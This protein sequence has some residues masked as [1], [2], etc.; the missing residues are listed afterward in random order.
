MILG[1]N[2]IQHLHTHQHSNMDLHRKSE[3]GS[4]DA[5]SVGDCSI[6]ETKPLYR[7]TNVYMETTWDSEVRK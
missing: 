3:A 2:Q 5:D 7:R 6:D 4:D 1:S